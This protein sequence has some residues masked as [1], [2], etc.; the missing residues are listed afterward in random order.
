[1]NQPPADPMA[2]SGPQEPFS[3]ASSAP[4]GGPFGQPP[5]GGF[6]SPPPDGFGG[7]PPGGFGGPPPGGF[8]GPPPGGFGG[9]PPG[10]FGSPPGGY[11]GPPPGGFGSPPGGPFGPPGGFGGPPGYVPFGTPIR[12]TSSSSS[13]GLIIGIVVAVFVLIGMMAA[14]A[15]F[16]VR[17]K[18]AGQAGA[19]ASARAEAA[20]GNDEPWSDEAASVPVTSR[21]PMWGSRTAPVTLVLFS[22]F[23]C[24]F[25]SKFETTI[26]AAREK[27]GPS[28][29]RVIWKN[30]PLPFHKEARPT[31]IAA[32]AVFRAGGSQAFWK[33][34]DSAFANQSGL[35]QDNFEA[36]ASAA[37]VDASRLR[38]LQ[39]DPEVAAKVDGDAAL[40][41]T[42]GVQGTPNT[43]VNG[44]LLTGAQPLEKLTALI[45]TEM[46]SAE[47][48]IAAGTPADRVYSKLSLENKTRNPAP[49]KEAE[50]D[51]DTKVYN[52][53]VG[54]SPSRGPATAKVTV[55]EFADF[56]CP[57]CV[58]VEPTLVQLRE[59]YGDKVRLVWKNQPLAFHSNAEPAAELALEA[60]AQ[61]GDAG[62]WAA[63]DLLFKN[64]KNLSG[65][66]LEGYAAQ[67][68]LDVGRVRKA[69][70][71]KKHGSVI[72]DD[73][74]L[75]TEVTATGTP[76]F[77]INGHKLTG[78]QPLE[79]FKTLI[80][81]E[82]AK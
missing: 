53:P 38:A 11:G 1:M 32:E 8:G 76:T 75:A 6:G 5:G 16:F 3:S 54:S 35:N 31:A 72:A 56:Q 61:N 19:A 30:Y 80:D 81:R 82:L 70:S 71:T 51:D 2:P 43:F 24:P 25:C 52:V 74:R 12:P 42:V 78:A 47:R 66:D 73:Q 20:Y 63:H 49:K 34:H 40:A 67:L 29:V 14:G 33:F 28:K 41:K 58:R 45:D 57:F 59:I 21:D 36:W 55:V 37:G 27:Y 48:A 50:P 7:P 62:F 39:A 9:P 79:K 23:Q 10:G 18:A 17:S 77:F 46:A 60:R 68:K 64:Q 4:G 15:I 26:A 13:A 65:D 22:D 44:F 69:I